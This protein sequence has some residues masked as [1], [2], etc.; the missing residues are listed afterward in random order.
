[1][2]CHEGVNKTVMFQMCHLEDTPLASEVR[3]AE[4]F[5]TTLRKLSHQTS[6]HR[7]RTP[8]GKHATTS[9]TGKPSLGALA[10]LASAA[11]SSVSVGTAVEK[12]KNISVYLGNH[13]ITG[14]S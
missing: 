6:T 11:A 1:M 5:H 14:C 8:S 2:H 4:E 13:A 9:M 3:F 10:G 12:V 7:S